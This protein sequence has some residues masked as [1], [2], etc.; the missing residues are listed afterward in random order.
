MPESDYIQTL[1]ASTQQ[2][3]T[4]REAF[5]IQAGGSKQFYGNQISVKALDV[6]GNTGIVDYDPSKLFITA[7]NGT[8]LKDIEA[9]LTTDNQMLPFEP[10]HFGSQATLGGTIVAAYLVHADLMQVQCAIVFLAHTSLT[11]KVNTWSLAVK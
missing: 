6:S 2:A 5:Q 7:R 3:S 11:V 9:T 1:C 4:S 10:P 8:L